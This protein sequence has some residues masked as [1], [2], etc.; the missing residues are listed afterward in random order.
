MN[1]LVRSI[2]VAADFCRKNVVGVM[3]C[4]RG[5]K[6]V[7]MMNCESRMVKSAC[8]ENNTENEIVVLN[9]YG[10]ISTLLELGEDRIRLV[11]KKEFGI[12]CC[13]LY[14]VGDG[15]YGLIVGENPTCTM[16]DI[17]GT[18][19]VEMFVGADKDLMASGTKLTEFL[20][21][22]CYFC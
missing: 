3:P 17:E 8:G 1:I 10:L 7:E 19:S 14:A 15:G 6:E 21:I 12:E 4:I 20:Y 9:D 16:Q 11:L 22:D 5:T 13:E 2:E 18:S